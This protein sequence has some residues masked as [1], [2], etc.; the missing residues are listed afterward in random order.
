MFLFQFLQNAFSGLAPL[1][2]QDYP[3]KVFLWQF[4]L[5][6][7]FLRQLDFQAAAGTVLPLHLFLLVVVGGCQ[8]PFAHMTH[9]NYMHH[10]HRGIV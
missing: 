5:E 8:A 10:R 6:L 1:Q 3:L 2:E 9:Y 4:P 7:R